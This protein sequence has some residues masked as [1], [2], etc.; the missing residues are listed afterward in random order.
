MS[1]LIGKT[2]SSKEALELDVQLYALNHGFALTTLHVNG[3]KHSEYVNCVHHGKIK[4]GNQEHQRKTKTMA[5]GCKWQIYARLPKKAREGETVPFWE[6]RK[7]TLHSGTIS[8]NKPEQGNIAGGNPHNHELIASANPKD[9][10]RC[11]I[12]HQKLSQ[13]VRK[14]LMV[15][16]GDLSTGSAIKMVEEN[17]PEVVVKRKTIYNYI[18]QQKS[19][20]GAS[21]E[22]D[23]LKVYLESEGYEVFYKVTPTTNVLKHLFT[24][25]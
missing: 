7:V 11:Y 25:H 13:D 2:Y 17:Y 12:Q 16:C 4:A 9:V 6:I 15:I 8:S 3:D 24:N 10:A 1:D 20:P 14:A 18:Q 22:F 19:V 23:P 5:R 21:T